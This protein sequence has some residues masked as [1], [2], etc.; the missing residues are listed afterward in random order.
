MPR[1]VSPIDEALLQGRM[2]TPALMRT[3][4]WL[5]AADLSTIST[6]TGVSELRDKSGNG[7]NFSQGTGGN[8]PILTPDGLNGRP[9]LTF[10]GSQFLNSVSPAATWN[11]LHNTNGSTVFAVWRAGNVSD[12]NAIY[13]LMGNNA[14]ASGNTG[15]YIVYD[16]RAS[17]SRNNRMLTQ[18]SR[19]VSGATSVFIETADGAHPP[20]T[21]VMLT[22]IAAPGNATAAS[23]S[24]LRI[25]R[26][27]VANNV[28]TN[29]PSAGNASFALQIG[30]VGNNIALHTGYIAE[31]VV[32]SSN[33]S[34]PDGLRIQGYLAHKWGLPGLLVASHP[35]IN[36]PPLIGA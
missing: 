21:P 28:D 32:L 19:G 17:S 2:W 12:P 25:N 31:I 33:V 8:Q 24:V 23:R 34:D 11:F 26:T 9:V 27:V 22:H 3:A 13:G 10:N 7:R 15:F 14:A 5:D 35:Y 30:G 4:L 1:G 18:I 29:A 6:A 36:R 16:D 20:N